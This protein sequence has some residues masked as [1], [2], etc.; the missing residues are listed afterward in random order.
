MSANHEVARGNGERGVSVLDPFRWD[1]FREIFGLR[2]NMERF[3]EEPRWMINLPKT[4]T[5]NVEETEKEYTL[6]ADVPG[7]DKKDISVEI[8]NGVLTISGERKDEKEEKG[9]NILRREQS[10]G[11]FMRSLN[12]P[13]DI[14]ASDIKASYKDGVL[15]MNIPRVE[16]AKPHG[17]KV[18][19]E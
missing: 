16:G 3:F 2:S 9:K 15:V 6:K 1:P 13:E 4:P 14:K 12:L 11:F 7:M 8:K 18:E 10:Y 19:V 5:L 17:V